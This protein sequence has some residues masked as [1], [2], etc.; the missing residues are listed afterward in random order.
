MNKAEK[1]KKEIADLNDLINTPGVPADEKGFA[2]SE[3]AKLEAKLKKSEPK[4]A[5]AK[6]E[7]KP[8][9][10]KKKNT[11]KTE[12][13]KKAPAKKKAASKNETPDCDT[14]IEQFKKRR[15]SYKKS[16]KKR[17][18]KSVFSVIVDKVEGAITK[19]INSVPK[20]D[21]ADDPKGMARKFEKLEANGR[22]FLE[23]FEDLNP[24]EYSLAEIKRMEAD[25]TKLIAGLKKTAEK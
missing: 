21:I 24:D 23:S 12:K 6:T 7:K 16:E 22:A 2:K 13:T 10:A 5:K 11:E 14:L 17:K 15:E 1:I 20:A 4:A 18:T 19:A 3:I 25:L 8:A 9:P